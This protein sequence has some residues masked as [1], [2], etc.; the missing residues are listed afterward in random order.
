MMLLATLNDTA[1]ADVDAQAARAAAVGVYWLELRSAWRMSI[2]EL[3]D[4]RLKTVVGVLSHHGVRA[5]CVDVPRWSTGNTPSQGWGLQREMFDRA[6]AAAAAT[7]APFV[8]LMADGAEPDGAAQDAVDRWLE[9]FRRCAEHAARAGVAV[10]VEPCAGWCAGT[11]ERWRAMVPALHAAGARALYDPRRF[12]SGGESAA[13][14]MAD[15]VIPLAAYIRLDG[16]SVGQWGRAGGLL[17]R[18]VREVRRRDC[19]VCVEWSGTAA[20]GGGESSADSFAKYT[21][22]VRC[23]RGIVEIPAEHAAPAAEQ[24]P[25][26]A[27]R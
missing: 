4:A 18:I 5:A 3:T 23:V 22:A 20:P 21:E 9:F 7:G 8:R 25:Q 10:L 11:P 27:E 12:A 14:A 19:F 2:V 1:V 6:V 13:E 15:A 24:S 16:A 17:E 26:E